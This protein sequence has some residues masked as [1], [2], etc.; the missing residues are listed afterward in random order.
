MLIVVFAVSVALL[1]LLLIEPLKQGLLR[2]RE[3]RWHGY[4]Q[5]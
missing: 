4:Y 1:A 2:R 5:N 3:R